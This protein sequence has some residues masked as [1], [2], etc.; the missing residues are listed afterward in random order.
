MVYDMKGRPGFETWF[1]P[2]REKLV[3]PV[4]R[5]HPASRR[6]NAPHARPVL[7]AR[8]FIASPPCDGIGWK[9]RVG[10]AI[11]ASRVRSRDSN[12]HDS[13]PSGKCQTRSGR[14]NDPAANYLSL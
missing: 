1:G 11:V 7:Q 6:P 3:G 5:P 12:C 14:W 4:S 13:Q 10:A 2:E 8:R 9:K